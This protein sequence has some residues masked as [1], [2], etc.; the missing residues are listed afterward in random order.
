MKRLCHTPNIAVAQLW[1][2]TLRAEGVAV[3]VQR[4]YVSS[5]AGDIP[6]DQALPELWVMREEDFEQG[7]Q[8]VQRLQ[9]APMRRW[10]CL[11]C[12]E[13]VEG[14]FES[15]WNCGAWSQG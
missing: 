13:T 7:A 14:A 1:A 9:H 10:T 12:G 8:I 5:I 6:P 11:E 15:C 3:T 2:D 4:H